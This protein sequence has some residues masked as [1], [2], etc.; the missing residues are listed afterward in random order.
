MSAQNTATT[1]PRPLA[2]P[3]RGPA[4]ERPGAPAITVSGLRK[5]YGDHTV[6]DGVDLTVPAGGIFALLGPNGA[7]KTTLINILTTLVRP[8]GGTARVLGHDVA[9]SPRRVRRAIS[10]TGQYASVDE[11]LTGRENLV[12][13]AR[14]LGSGRRA[15]DERAR[16]LLE[17][18]DL[19]DAADRR[20]GDYSGGMRRRLDLAASLVGSPPVVFL[21]EP[22]TGMD[23]RSRQTLWDTVTDLAAGG[24]TVFLTTQYL[25][26]ADVLADRIA[27]LDGGVIAAEGTADELKRRIGR[28]LIELTLADGS[29]EWLRGDG[30]AEHL[31]SVLNERHRSD[32]P[33]ARVTVHTPTLDDV[34]LA[35]TDRSA[36]KG[37]AS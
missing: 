37:R 36:T 29:S 9:R 32:L 21:D 6:L 34:F 15:A 27:V 11:V 5:R 13:I 17:R 8:D 7:G 35:L 33:V 16:E 4:S 26:E 18:F 2:E 3:A 20:A 12:M 1:E 10:A 25:E 30:T 24:T 19:A 22:T 31:R 14:L 28:E 23:T